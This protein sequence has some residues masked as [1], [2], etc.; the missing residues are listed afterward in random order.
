[1]GFRVQPEGLDT[2][3]S[4]LKGLQDDL[5]TAQDYL[6]QHLSYDYG[7]ARMFATIAN[8]N[9]ATKAAVG[10]NLKHLDQLLSASAGELVKSANMY[11]E[12]DANEE[13]RLDET[14]PSS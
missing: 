3:A 6:N 12:T 2:Y 9:N 4:L 11:R 10:D 7:D 1:M 14:Y 5:K 13:R 8:A